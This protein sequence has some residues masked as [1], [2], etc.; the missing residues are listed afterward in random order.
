M[1]NR[2]AGFSRPATV[3]IAFSQLVVLRD[4]L[5]GLPHPDDRGLMLWSTT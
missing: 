4:M 3:S 5:D 1:Q 2:L